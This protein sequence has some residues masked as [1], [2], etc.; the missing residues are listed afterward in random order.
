MLCLNMTV[1]VSS[2]FEPPIAVLTMMPVF[3]LLVLIT[4]LFPAE[5]IVAII[6]LMIVGM[7]GTVG[8]MI[9]VAVEVEGSTAAGRHCSGRKVVE[10]NGE[11]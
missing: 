2:K 11:G 10:L 1:E 5:G 4:V 3:L 7:H 8:N 6:A 9:A